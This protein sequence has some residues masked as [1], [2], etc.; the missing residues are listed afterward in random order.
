MAVTFRDQLF[1]L[2]PP[3]LRADV[4]GTILRA[5][6]MVLDA[7]TDRVNQGVKLR[8]PIIGSPTA[9]GYT[10]ADRNIE[11]GPTQSDGGYA[12][13][14][15]AA[16]DTWANAGSARTLLA[17]LRFFFAPGNGPAMRT[18]SAQAV[19]HE[20]NPST[21]VV[22]KTDKALAS[23]W[24]WGDGKWYRAWAIVDATG[25]W[26]LDY[27]EAAHTSVW[28]DGGLWGC[29]M[30]PGD[31]QYFKLVVE[32]WR[33]KNVFAQ[34]VL[35]FDATLF[36]VAASSP[37]NPSGLGYR[38]SWRRAVLANFAEVQDPIRVNPPLPYPR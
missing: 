19:W 15:Q 37:P 2:S 7:L 11:R 33:P 28:G 8:F 29:D 12:L 23:N 10:G 9:L 22:T 36:T 20:M 34:L 1:E 25:L 14:L 4:G 17:Q 38:S 6:G 3:W 26:T 24:N 16:F 32:K 18:V 31:A 13:Q 5:F 27:Y 21:G 30:A 35:I